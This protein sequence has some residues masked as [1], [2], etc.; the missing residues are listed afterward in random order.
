MANANAA[1]EADA[2]LAESYEELAKRRDRPLR[3]QRLENAERQQL[4][5]RQRGIRQLREQ[6]QRMEI[7][8]EQADREEPRIPREVR[9]NRMTL[10]ASPISARRAEGLDDSVAPPAR[11]EAPQ[12]DE[13]VEPRQRRGRRASEAP[14][15]PRPTASGPR[16]ERTR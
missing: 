9:Q 6:R 7:E 5:E 16:C 2:L 4:M 8:D 11:A 10:P 15:E 3:V 12:P 1:S 14:G 13:K